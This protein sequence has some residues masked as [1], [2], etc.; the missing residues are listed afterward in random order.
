[1][2]TPSTGLPSLSCPAAEPGAQI[3]HVEA[4]FPASLPS[5]AIMSWTFSFIEENMSSAHDQQERR[6]RPGVRSDEGVPVARRAVFNLSGAIRAG[7]AI[8]GPGS[9]TGRSTA[10]DGLPDP[11]RGVTDGVTLRARVL[12]TCAILLR[13]RCAGSPQCLRHFRAEELAGAIA[14]DQSQPEELTRDWAAKMDREVSGCGSQRGS[15]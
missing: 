3:Y 14:A 5:R 1:M 12:S 15:R 8:S 9:C 11:L 13:D 6:Q 10:D 4:A 7:V 2:A